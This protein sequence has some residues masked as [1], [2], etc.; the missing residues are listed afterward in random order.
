M[1]LPDVQHDGEAYAVENGCVRVPLWQIKGL[2]ER[3]LEHW[4][5]ARE[6]G[7]FRDWADFIRRTRVEPADAEL[8]ARAG[9]LRAFFPNRHE[10]FWRAGQAGG[11]RVAGKG[12]DGP[13]LFGTDG[14]V[15]PSDFRPM[16]CMAMA[17]AEA[18]LL[19]F[20]VSLDP[21]ALWM[22][23]V[24]R[25]HTVPVREIAGIQVGH[26]LHRTGKGGLM[27]FVSLADESGMAGTV[28]FPDAYR[29]LGWDLS[30]ARAARL[31]VLV[32]WDETRSG[33]SLTVVEAGAFG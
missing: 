29:R 22:A 12:G 32:E 20:P 4:R 33:L 21:F 23:D 15:E 14:R 6:K 13:E 31:R 2:G 19:G 11:R 3:F 7:P 8:L 16:G 5:K 28:L 18:E 30:Q 26:G 17:E 9:A 27:K 10:A 24:E 1:T 25:H